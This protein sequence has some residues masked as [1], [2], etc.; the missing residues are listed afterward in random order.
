MT[1]YEPQQA[2]EL[3]RLLKLRKPT[4]LQLMDIERLVGILGVYGEQL[5]KIANEDA[6]Q[7]RDLL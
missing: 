7:H 2:R 4:Q 1:G 3:A 6:G 5:Y